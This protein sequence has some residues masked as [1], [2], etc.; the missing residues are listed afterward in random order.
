MDLGA[1][2]LEARDGM[3]LPGNEAYNNASL[4]PIAFVRKA[5]PA[6]KG[7]ITTLKEKP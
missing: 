5:S 2:L 6:L 4:Q 7:S 3:Q 1:N